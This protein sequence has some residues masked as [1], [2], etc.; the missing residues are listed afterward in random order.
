MSTS[1]NLTLKRGPSVW[2][3]RPVSPTKNWRALGVAAGAVL[4]SLALRPRT[5]RYWLI[6]VGLGVAGAYLVGDRF[7]STMTAG[8]RRIFPGGRDDLAVDRASEDSFPASDPTPY[9]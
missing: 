6:G 3:D 4:A 9:L 1:L 8:M 5:N 7:A 2:D